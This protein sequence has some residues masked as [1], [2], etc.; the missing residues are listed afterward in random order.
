[1]AT[2]TIPNTFANSTTA[3]AT[4]VNA[5]FTAVKD[6]ID[7]EVIQKDGSKAF[8]G[9]V[10][11]PATDPTAADHL[12]RKAYVDAQIAT[13]A[14]S[15]HT[16]AAGDVTSGTFATARIPSLAASI[17]TSGTFDTARIPNLAA[18]KIT[19][20]TFANARIP[21][22]ISGKTSIGSTTLDVEGG[23]GKI[24]F[25]GSSSNYIDYDNTYTGL[26][27]FGKSGAAFGVATIGAQGMTYPDLGLNDKMAFGWDATGTGR[28][29]VFVNGT[30]EGY[31]Q[32]TT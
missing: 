15:S 13:R 27:T 12:S 8:T 25:A 1:M 23:S 20:G 32:L 9:L 21:A 30:D 26:F 28:L 29:R 16:H 6:F 22:T 24:I 14:A 5:N 7:D 10:S 18:S 17:I 4:Q 31:I 19:S 11:G 2:L 3:D